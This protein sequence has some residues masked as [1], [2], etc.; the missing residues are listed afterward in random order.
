MVVD[1]TDLLNRRHL[2]NDMKD[3]RMLL[4]Y[5]AL[6]ED[7]ADG[8]SSQLGFDAVLRHGHSELSPGDDAE[9]EEDEDKDEVTI[10]TYGNGVVAA[11]EAQR[12]LAKDHGITR[13]GILEVPCISAMPPALGHGLTKHA[14]GGVVFADICK[15]PQA[16]LNA[17]VVQLQDQGLLAH[18]WRCVAAPQ[19]YNPLAST[20]TFLSSQDIV[21][22]ALAVS[23]E[24]SS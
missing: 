1:S 7:E 12:I 20:I 2:D 9:E 10:V 5:P 24:D 13:V 21:E 14:H 17:F 15:A 23:R 18:R 6:P 16:P 4:P 3:S 8:L 22:A 11:V 19:T